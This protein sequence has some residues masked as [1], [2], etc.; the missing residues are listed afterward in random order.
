MDK[1]L[2]RRSGN[3]I[4]QKMREQDYEKLSVFILSVLERAGSEGMTLHDLVQEAQ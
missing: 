2:S 1:E 3:R 4:E